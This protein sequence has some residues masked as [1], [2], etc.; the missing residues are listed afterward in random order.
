MTM[1]PHDASGEWISEMVLRDGRILRLTGP[2][3]ALLKPD[4]TFESSH[5]LSEIADC[6]NPKETREV[7]LRLW[8]NEELTLLA[9]SSADTNQIVQWASNAPRLQRRATNQRAERMEKARM[10]LIGGGV[11]IAIGFGLLILLGLLSSP[12]SYYLLPIGLLAFGGMGFVV[13][14]IQY[15]RA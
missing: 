5:M 9:S 13:G 11:S 14:I 1:R 2:R 15:Y 8:N 7:F 6:S 4:G 3:L 10:R 12:P